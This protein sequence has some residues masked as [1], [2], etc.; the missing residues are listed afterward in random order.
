VSP[1]VHPPRDEELLC[2]G[3]GRIFFFGRWP[4]WKLSFVDKPNVDPISLKVFPYFFILKLNHILTYQIFKMD[5]I[6]EW[7]H[8]LVYK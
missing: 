7:K 2:F 3:N 4:N 6:L 8:L 5:T 1:L